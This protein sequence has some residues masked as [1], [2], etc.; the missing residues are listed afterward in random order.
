MV[1]FRRSFVLV[2]KSLD[3]RLQEQIIDLIVLA[4]KIEVELI[5]K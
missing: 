3:V 1:L 2:Q 5:R 4:K